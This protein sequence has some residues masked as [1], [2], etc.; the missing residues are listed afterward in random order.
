LEADA[1]EFDLREYEEAIQNLVEQVARCSE[2]VDV[3]PRDEDDEEERRDEEDE[4]DR[5]DENQE[6][7]R[8]EEGDDQDQW[9][10]E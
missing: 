8:D 4:D 10:D 2:G 7:R 1:A 6:D 5:R 3:E 9:R